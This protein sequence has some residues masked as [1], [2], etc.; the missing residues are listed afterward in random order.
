MAA[1]ALIYFNRDLLHPSL[2]HPRVGYIW[3]VGFK[4][5][6]VHVQLL[7]G[8]LIIWLIFAV[9]DDIVSRAI[10]RKKKAVQYQSN[11]IPVSKYTIQYIIT[12]IKESLV[13]YSRYVI[14][15][16]LG[17]LDTNQCT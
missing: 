5:T 4:S 10:G 15:W 11:I 8:L 12:N 2:L 14:L 16:A 17:R 6:F 9:K 13:A 7:P 3:Y 1:G